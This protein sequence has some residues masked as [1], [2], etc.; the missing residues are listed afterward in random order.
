MS[1]DTDET[2]L[3]FHPPTGESLS[4]ALAGIDAGTPASVRIRLTADQW[5]RVIDESLFSVETE[6]ERPSVVDGAIIEAELQATDSVDG[7][8]SAEAIRHRLGSGDDPLCQTESW[9]VVSLQEDL[10]ALST[11]DLVSDVLEGNYEIHPPGEY[12]KPVA[13]E[14]VLETVTAYLDAEDWPYRIVEDETDCYVRTAV[15]FDEGHEWNVAIHIEE[16]STRCMVYSTFPEPISSEMLPDLGALLV[17]KN[18]D[19]LTSAFEVDPTESELT[20]RTIIYPK[21]DSFE[22]RLLENVFGMNE[23]YDAI[24]DIVSVGT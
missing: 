3:T 7:E 2:A 14:S 8:L 4:V 24:A 10:S 18:Y 5:D 22:K 23:A 15:K 9:H 13:S 12:D 1:S 16:Q 19:Y 21:S 17:T 6:G 20:F 11:E